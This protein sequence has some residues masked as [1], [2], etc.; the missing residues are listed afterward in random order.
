MNEIDL[1][2][3]MILITSAFTVQ[4]SQPSHKANQQNILSM[5]VTLLDAFIEISIL[6]TKTLLTNINCLSRNPIQGMKR[7]IQTISSAILPLLY[8]RSIPYCQTLL[9]VYRSETWIHSFPNM[10]ASRFRNAEKSNETISASMQELSETV[11]VVE[12]RGKC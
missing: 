3:T 6:D 11:R 8:K 4:L 5:P 9:I 2:I 10:K 7:S 1:V 12:L